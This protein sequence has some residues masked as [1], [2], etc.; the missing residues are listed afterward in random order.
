MSE[1][2]AP[3][4]NGS[5]ARYKWLPINGKDH[6]VDQERSETVVR[7]YPNFPVGMR[8]AQ[9]FWGG[10]SSLI[11]VGGFVALIWLPWYTPLIGL[12]VAY[13][14]FGLDHRAGHLRPLRIIA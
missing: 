8:A 3:R 1:F 5:L 13:I 12:C 7:E 2:V 6:A 10:I 4:S 11:F 9:K 14:T